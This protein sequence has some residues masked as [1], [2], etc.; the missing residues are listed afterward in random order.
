MKKKVQDHFGQERLEELSHVLKRIHPGFGRVPWFKVLRAIH[1]ETGG[2]E[3]GFELANRWSSQG[4]NYMGSKDVRK[5]WQ[6]I[7]SGPRPITLLSLIWMARLMT[8]LYG[9][10]K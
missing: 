10:Q 6:S 7:K 1:H 9:A 4:Q 3:G 2:G 5:H 8:M